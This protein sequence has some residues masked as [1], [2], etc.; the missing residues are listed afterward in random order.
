MLQAAI[1]R[2]AGNLEFL[3]PSPVHEAIISLLS[4]LLIGGWLKEKY[5]PK[6]Q[7][8]FADAR[9]TVI[10]TLSPAFGPKT[11]MRLA[12]AVVEGDRGKMVDR[13]KPLRIA[14][15]L[16]ALRHKP[17]RTRS[18]LRQIPCL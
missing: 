6:V 10:A 7:R 12:N 4:S 18:G 1:P 2:R 17:L 14:L 3:V 8:T 11:A 9:M 13:V 16:H 5:F 15:A